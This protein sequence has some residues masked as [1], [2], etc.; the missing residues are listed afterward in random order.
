MR[1]NLVVRKGNKFT[2]DESKVLPYMKDSKDLILAAIA[3]AS[4]ELKSSPSQSSSQVKLQELNDRVYELL[5]AWKVY[6]G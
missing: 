3:V 4:N 5:A 2:F 1:P 6:K